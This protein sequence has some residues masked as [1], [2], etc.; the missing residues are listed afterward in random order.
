MNQQYRV[1][2]IELKEMIVKFQQELKNSIIKT[3]Q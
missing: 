1:N 3:T 2:E